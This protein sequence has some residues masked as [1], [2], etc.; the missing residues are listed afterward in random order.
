VPPR[1]REIFAA[2]SPGTDSP[3]VICGLRRVKI[4][5]SGTSH[6][7]LLFSSRL[8]PKTLSPKY[9]STMARFGTARENSKIAGLY[10]LFPGD[11]VLLPLRNM[12]PL[13]KDSV[14]VANSTTA[15]PAA[16]SS[17]SPK[18]AAAGG[19]LRADALSLEVPVKVHG[20][21][22]TEVARGVAPHTEP[23][24]EETGTMIV[25]PHGGVLRMSTPVTASQMLVVTNLKT[26][27]DAIC[28]VV[29]VRTFS[30]MQGYVEV[31]FTH[32]QPGYWGVHFPSEGPAATPVIQ[33]APVISAAAP[34]VIPETPVKAAP[35]QNVSMPVAPAAPVAFVAPVAPPPAAPV[36]P[37]A[38]TPPPPPP[39]VIPAAPSKPEPTFISLGTQEKVQPAASATSPARPELFAP[40]SHVAPTPTRSESVPPAFTS[41][42]PLSALPATSAA[43]GALPS[44]PVDFPAPPQAVTPASLT[45]TE[46]RGDQRGTVVIAPADALT[47]IAGAEQHAA[48]V[49]EAPAQSSRAVFGSFSG[50]ASLSGSHAVPVDAFGARLDS[51]SEAGAEHAGAPRGNNWIL[52]AACVTLLFATVVG[53]VLYFRPHAASSARNGASNS[54]SPAIPQPLA[55]QTPAAAPDLR[56]SDV[57]P[58]HNSAIHPV[59]VIAQAP[60]VAPSIV[61]NG[62]DANGEGPR[63]VPKPAS[64]LAPGVLKNGG[65]DHPVAPQ[66]SDVDQAVQAPSLDAAPAGDSA[67]G[68][69]LSGIV[70]SNA[71]APAAPALQPEGVAKVGG[72][73]KEPRLLSRVMPEYPLVAKQAGIQGD[74]VVKTTIDL[75][76]DPVNLQVVSGPAMLRGP[77]L[78]ALRRWK[79][80][81]STL[82]GQPIAVQMLVTIK[83]SGTR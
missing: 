39:P 32:Q 73:V 9:Q 60:G 55:F 58:V 25:F 43:N 68:S 53:G 83:F 54:N 72:I 26:R 21:R 10:V 11:G 5:R 81:P 71:A 17:V 8:V 57:A 31:E 63:I 37:A 61:V 2:L 74:V 27:Q 16:Q 70:S 49:A 3:P 42:E 15:A 56:T 66:R 22:V 48:E 79:Y 69:A 67:N 7:R 45:M 62:N 80:E 76:G 77:A 44:T 30:N 34:V 38:F 29:K 47:A 36:V 40:V 24:E 4:F 12:A 64:N 46:L 78:A 13:I 35:V 14:E 19:A 51:T 28:R 33:T 6:F 1:A 20:S 52:I 23:F 18:P 59:P 65:E 82:N 41:S 75:K 50:G